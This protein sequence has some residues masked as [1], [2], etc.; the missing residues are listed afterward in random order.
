MNPINKKDSKCFPYVVAVALNYEEIK[1][2]P[3]RI[4]KIK[5]FINKYNWEG[6]PFINKYNW[7]GINF[8]WEKDGWKKFEKNIVTNSLNVLYAKK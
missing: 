7:E 4:T 2:N 1:K 5:P 6:M 3:Q 8:Q